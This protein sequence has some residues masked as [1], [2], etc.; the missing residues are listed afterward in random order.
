MTETNGAIAR[1]VIHDLE[2]LLEQLDPDVVWDNRGASPP[3]HGGVYRGRAEV[4]RII[5]EW[6]GSWAEYRIDVDEV[7]EV[8]DDVILVVRE[9]GLGK[10]SGAPIRNHHCYV[11]SFRNGL[12]IGGSGGY[13]SKASALEAIRN[14]PARP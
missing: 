9:S 4:S 11:W 1:R 2:A 12:I 8:G 7:V 5:R 14:R 6:V 3:D 10:A 13:E